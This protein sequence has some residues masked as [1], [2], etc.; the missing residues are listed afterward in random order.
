MLDK[1]EHILNYKLFVINNVQITVFHVV[2]VAIIL[3]I[4]FFVLKIIQRILK[5]TV[6]RKK[7]HPG[8]LYSVYQIIKY[9]LWVISALLSLQTLGFNLNVIL[10]SGAAL[11]VGLGLGIQQLFNDYASGIILLVEQNLKLFD[12]V[13]LNDGTVGKVIF[14]GLRTSKIETR[15]NI[16]IIVPNHKLINDNVI[17]W[18]HIESNTRF[19]LDVGVAYGSD[20]ELVRSVLLK[21]AEENPNIK[22]KPSPMVLFKDFGDSSLDFSLLIWTDKTWLIEPIKSELRFAINKAFKE[23]NIEIPFPQTDVHLYNT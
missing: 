17:N 22:S 8:S 19:S 9:F 21:C 7:L 2:A 4:T 1:V 3:L 5:K 12:I 14:I 23:N 13:E 6:E 18:S 10:A 16:V 11:L 20:V 15:D